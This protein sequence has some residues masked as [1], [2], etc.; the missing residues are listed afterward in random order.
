MTLWNKPTRRLVLRSGACLACVPLG[1]ALLGCSTDGGSTGHGTVTQCTGG[2]CVDL[3]AAA[4]K[5]LTQ[6]GGS[7]V[8]GLGGDTVI[9]ARTASSTVIALSAI[10]T[11]LGCEVGFQSGSNNFLCPCHG[12]MYDSQGNVTRGPAT[13]PLKRYMATLSG[14]TVTITS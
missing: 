6:V 5:P 13:L 8:V 14:N 7:V 12:S 3:T 2:F 9:V 10:C 1:H 4:N 11:H